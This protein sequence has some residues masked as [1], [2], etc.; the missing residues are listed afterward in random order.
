VQPE[1]QRWL[2]ENVGWLP[3]RQDVDYAPVTDKIPRFKAFLKMPT[4]DWTFFTIPGLPVIDEIETKLAEGHLVPAFVNRDLLD[5]PTGIAEVI[6]R[7]AAET[8]SIL[9]GAGLQ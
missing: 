1:Y 4:Q 9:K 2:L 5:N 8:D 6:K 3:N 7:A